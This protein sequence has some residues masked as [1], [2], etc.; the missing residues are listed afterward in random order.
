M[1][2]GGGREVVVVA[3]GS[4]QYLCLAAA[5]RGR[6]NNSISSIRKCLIER[7][8]PSQGLHTHHTC[9][10]ATGDS[11]VAVVGPGGQGIDKIIT[12]DTRGGLLYL[13][14]ATQEEDWPS[15]SP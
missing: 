13:I 11:W 4:G 9:R 8:R 2:R 12:S 1:W 7:S 15:D 6:K 14:A 3:G 10:V 5:N